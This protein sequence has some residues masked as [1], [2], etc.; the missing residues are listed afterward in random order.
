MMV[1]ATEVVIGGRML[2]RDLGFGQTRLQA[3]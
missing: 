1:L 2:V 3:A